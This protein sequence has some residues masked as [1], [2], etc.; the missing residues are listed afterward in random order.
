MKQL[1]TKVGLWFV[2]VANVV[3]AY[4]SVK[5]IGNG[6]LKE[7]NPLMAVLLDTNPVL[8]VTVKTI[9]VL[10]GIYLMMRHSDKLLTQLGAYFLFMVYFTLIL[11]FYYFI[12]PELIFKN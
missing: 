1:L 6:P 7:A 2:L 12:P 8:F 9:L 5:V 4:V 10:S 3:D 11:C